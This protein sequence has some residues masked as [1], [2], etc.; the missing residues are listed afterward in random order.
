MQGLYIVAL[1][2]SKPF[3]GQTGGRD[4]GGLGVFTTMGT[5][6]AVGLVKLQLWKR[7]NHD[8]IAID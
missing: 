3:F 1:C 6:C 2:D 7:V 8:R 4:L 5:G